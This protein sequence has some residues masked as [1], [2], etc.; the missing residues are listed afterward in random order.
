M[1]TDES[2]DYSTFYRAVISLYLTR[3]NHLEFVPMFDYI[4][5]IY[6]D[7]NII[8]GMLMYGPPA[9][10]PPTDAYARHIVILFHPF[11]QNIALF[12]HSYYFLFNRDQY[13]LHISEYV[14]FRPIIQIITI[15]YNQRYTKYTDNDWIK[16]KSSIAIILYSIEK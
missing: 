13:I 16:N 14:S 9:S 15:I 2:D 12:L 10:F 1:A 3:E 6:G 11:K 5:S 7:S 8:T 4:K